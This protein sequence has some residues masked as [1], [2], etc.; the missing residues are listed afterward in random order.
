MPHLFINLL[1]ANVFLILNGTIGHIVDETLTMPHC[2]I[3]N[4]ESKQTTMEVC[5]FTTGQIKSKNGYL[6]H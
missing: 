4:G 1:I 6:S 5:N 2:V 3:L